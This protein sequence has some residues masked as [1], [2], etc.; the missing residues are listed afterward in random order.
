MNLRQ[1]SSMKEGPVLDLETGDLLGHIASWVIHPR[2][3]R[4]AAWLLGR[5]KLFQAPLAVVTAD[6][7]EYGPRMVVVRDSQPVIRP[8]EVVGLPELITARMVVVGFQATTVQGRVLGSVADLVFDTIS[9]QI[10]QYYIRPQSMAGFLQNDLVLPANQV[11]RIE[12]NRVVFSEGVE[13]IPIVNPRK[14]VQTA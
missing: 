11:T 10:Q 9:S 12:S 1:I 13:A 3:Q 14:Q 7:A 8:D 6:I 2:D 5:N 4:I